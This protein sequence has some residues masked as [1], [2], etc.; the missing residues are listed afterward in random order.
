[1]APTD[2]TL[3]FNRQAHNRAIIPNN[4]HVPGCVFVHSQGVQEAGELMVARSLNLAKLALSCEWELSP[5]LQPEAYVLSPRRRHGG[6]ACER[7]Q[8]KGGVKEPDNLLTRSVTKNLTGTDGAFH[9][10]SRRQNQPVHGEQLPGPARLWGPFLAIISSA[11][12]SFRHI[13]FNL[14]LRVVAVQT[15]IVF[16]DK[17]M[18]QDSPIYIPTDSSH[19]AMDSH[20][21]QETATT[22]ASEHLD[23]SNNESTSGD[24]EGEGKKTRGKTLS[25]NCAPAPS[26]KLEQAQKMAEKFIKEKEVHKANRELIRCVALTRIIYGDGHWQLAQAFANLAHSYLI[27]RDLPAQAIEHAESAKRTMLTGNHTPPED[28]IEILGTLVT[29]YYI[30]GVAHLA[31]NNGKESYLSLQKAERLME[32]LKEL[33]GTMTVGLKISE[34]DL[35][36]A[37]GRTCLQ[38]N[39]LVFATGYFEKAVDAVISAE[40]D[41]APELIHLYQKIAQSEQLKKNHERAIGYLLQAHS[42]CVAL[43]KKLSAEAAQT[44]LLLGKA[45]AATGEQQHIAGIQAAER[46]IKVHH[47]H[48]W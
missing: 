46:F 31:Q 27:L 23:E 15:S 43:H 34:K 36:I 19:G 30:L 20:L 17:K 38:Q 4:M 39:K 44:G 48:L 13:I 41:T 40:G 7:S 28:K 35:V 1:M 18:M 11:V 25:M 22:T 33:N 47:R 9:G 10:G 5:R 37:L 2:H 26:E 12:S 45:Y 42:I 14:W 29:I 21:S 6:G 3:L 8:A 32:E 16:L 24:S